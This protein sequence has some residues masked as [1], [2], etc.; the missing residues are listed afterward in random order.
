[1]SNYAIVENTLVINTCVWDGT[2]DWTP[3]E[4]TTAVQI[5]VDSVAGVG[6]SYIDGQFIAP[7]IP[8]ISASDN[9]ATADSILSE[10]EWTSIPAIGNPELSNPY[11][12]NQA[13]WLYYRS[14]IRDIALNPPEGNVDWITPPQEFWSN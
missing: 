12:T 11:L 7:V 3:P 1:M 8:P 14:K 4:G 6:Y 13:E 9:K 10:T 2:S 5:P